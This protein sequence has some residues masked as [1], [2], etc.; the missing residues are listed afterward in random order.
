M[1][2]AKQDWSMSRYSWILPWDSLAAEYAR[3]VLEKDT[4]HYWKL[5]VVYRNLRNLELAVA[6]ADSAR[7][8]CRED[9]EELP[10]NPNRSSNYGL[11]LSF[12]GDCDTAIALGLRGKEF[13]PT[14]E[15]FW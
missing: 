2:F 1:E 14:D 10:D 8:S 15:C 9:W 4:V 11:L 6:Y 12:L 7:E 5:Y 3:E 13:M